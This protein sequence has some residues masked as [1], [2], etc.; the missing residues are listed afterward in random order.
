MAST[1]RLVLHVGMPKTGSTSIQRTLFYELADPGFRYVGLGEIYT[2]RA[3][4]SLFGD[5]PACY[6]V[7]D[8]LGLDATDLKCRRERYLGRLVSAL[9]ACDARHAVPIVSAERCWAMTGVELTRLREFFAGMG[10]LPEVL[11]YVR[12]LLE[13]YPSAFQEWVKWG[14][15]RFRPF[16][17][18]GEKSIGRDQGDIVAGLMTLDETF[19][20]ENVRVAAFERNRLEAGCV[21]SDFCHRVGIGRAPSRIHRANDSLGLDAVKLLY[22]YYC[23][24]PGYGRGR[25]VVQENQRLQRRLSALGGRPFRFHSSLFRGIAEEIGRQHAALS[26]RLGTRFG[27]EA[28]GADDEH[29]I[30]EES[31]LFR[32]SQESLRWLRDAVGDRTPVG[33]PSPE[34]RS[35][36]ASLVDRLRRQTAWRDR[37]AGGLETLRREVR[38][39]RSDV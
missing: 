12:P 1:K 36:V 5:D 24:G 27:G 35:I 30:R 31:D 19:G 3:M 34:V 23:D 18:F 38:S 10:Y 17:S 15:A 6:P 25:R 28:L 14:G 33:D 22:A 21:V 7:H 13:W 4:E 29:G 32:H 20:R 8:R 11:V 2:N 37:V 26:Q 9:E 16:Q 39:F